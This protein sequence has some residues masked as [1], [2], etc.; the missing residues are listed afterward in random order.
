MYYVTILNV[1]NRF[2]LQTK[3]TNHANI[4][5]LNIWQLCRKPMANIPPLY[6]MWQCLPDV[7]YKATCSPLAGKKTK[8][9]YAGFRL[10]HISVCYYVTVTILVAQN[11]NVRASVFLLVNVTDVTKIIKIEKTTYSSLSVGT[12]CIFT[13]FSI[14]LWILLIY[15]SY[16]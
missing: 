13:G 1:K 16:I 5:M 10:D 4:T 3:Q 15:K 7:A 8:L 14:Y 2:H 9:C 6:C 12:I 11:K